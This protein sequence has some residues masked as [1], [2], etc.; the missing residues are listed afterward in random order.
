[1]DLEFLDLYNRELNLFYERAK[2]F[3][4]EYP[5]IAERLGLITRENTDPAIAGLL[6]G[7]AFLAA[8]VQLKL[9]HEFPEFT[10]NL[11]EQLVPGFLAPTPSAILARVNPKFGD[12]ALREGIAIA[13][14]SALDAT[15]I[16]RERNVACRY[17]TTSPITLWPFDITRAE[18]I[19]GA[20]PLQ[21]LGV[22]AGPEALAGLRLTLTFRTAARI[23]DEKQKPGAEP[24]PQTLFAGCRTRELPVHLLGNEA[25]AVALY[26]QLFAQRLG[27]F[28]RKL[29]AF[30]DP[31]VT[32]LPPDS[33]EQIGFAR[34]E[35]LLPDDRRIFRGFHLLRE[36]FLFPRKFLGF[37]L[38]GLQ[39]FLPRMNVRTLDLI[40]TFKEVNPRLAAAIQPGFFAL[41]A[42]PAINLFEKL[43]DRIQIK[44]GQH[45][46]HVVADRTQHLSFEPHSIL[47]VHAHLPG[48]TDKQALF[49][50]YSEL[51][52]SAAADS[53]LFYTVRRLPRRRSQEERRLATASDYTGT[54]VFLSVTTPADMSDN[55]IA[56]LSLRALC[57]N[58]H[59]P[60]H[61]P[62][63]LGGADF[64]FTED[65]TLNVT[66]AAGPTKPRGPVAAQQRGRGETVSTGG[67]TWRLINMLSLN[68]HGLVDHEPHQP[69]QALREILAIFADL[70]DSATERRIRGVRSVKSRAVVRRLEQRT[71][72]GAARGLEVT[73]TI[74]ERSFEGSGIFLLGAVLDHF[75]AEYA[76]INHFTQTVIVSTERGEIMRWPARGGSR[77]VM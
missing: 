20:G 4:D 50:L 54:D 40:I 63:G 49:P 41:Y 43:T 67:V 46:Y 23:E 58:R 1:M 60:E 38:K 69:G 72:V 3:A 36:M 42:A 71:G 68:Q 45:E 57:S 44:P 17:T 31:V 74:D 73:V 29:D 34:E 14:G 76:G 75:I 5:G 2:E 33:I 8:R 55:G 35:A 10:G 52:E 65:T 66:C 11:I 15:Y 6:E 24:D 39:S 70:T 51:P 56:E 64:H 18:Y 27:I 7:A 16:Q 62:V 26:E 53:A 61:L 19:L 47:S 13:R 12:A 59:L 30:G 22:P 21:A 37:R 9:K 32:S 25:D 48:R 77:R 28:V